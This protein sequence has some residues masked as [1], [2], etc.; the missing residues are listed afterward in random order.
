MRLIF[1]LVSVVVLLTAGLL[2]G[3]SFMDWNKYKPQIIEQVKTLTGYDIA[4]GGDIGLSL[5]PS[6][7]VHL[8][9]VT[10]SAPRKVKA[11]NVISVKQA[12]VSLALL[13]LL[14]K[15]I[16]VSTVSLVDPDIRFEI[17]PGGEQGWMSDT[18]KSVQAAS[19]SGVATEGQ[20]TPSNSTDN[21]ALNRIEIKNGRVEFTDH[22]KGVSYLAEKIDV[23]VSADTLKGPFKA[24]GNLVYNNQ[25]LALN[26]KTGRMVSDSKDLELQVK[27]SAPDAGA[28]ISFSGVVGTGG[29]VE[30]QGETS[31]SVQNMARAVAALSG[32]A[33]SGVPAQKLSF[34]GLVTVGP[35]EAKMAN[36]DFTVGDASGTGTVTVQNVLAKNPVKVDADLTLKGVLDLDALAPASGGQGKAADGKA[37][38]AAPKKA[39]MLPASITLPMA[40]DGSVKLNA[41]GIKTGGQTLKGVVLDI[42]KTGPRIAAA[43]KLLNVPGGGNLDGKAAINFASSSVSEK[44]GAVTYADPSLVFN[45]TGAVDQWP[46]LMAALGQKGPAANLTDTAQ[47]VLSGDVTGGTVNVK[48][49]NLKL[50]D[51]AATL[52]AAYRPD[53]AGGKPDVMVDLTTDRIDVDAIQARMNGGKAKPAPA[54]D[55]PAA[56]PDMKAALKPV[57]EFSLPVNLTFDISAGSARV[58]GMDIK[59]VRLKGVSQGSSLK[60]DAASAENIMGASAS[61]KGQVAS[62]SDLSGIDMDFYGRTDDAEGLM[63][64][65]KVDASKLPTKIGPAE[66]K[67]S[68]KGKLESLGFVANIDALSGQLNAAGTVVDALGSPAFDNLTFGVKHPNFVQAMKIVSPAF[69]GGAGLARPFDFYAKTTRSGNAYDLTDIKGNFGSTSMTGTLNVNTGGARPDVSGRVQ[70]G[71]LPLDSYLGA[72]AGAS[73]GSDSGGGGSAAPKADS[74]WSTAPLDFGWMKSADMDLDLS[75]SSI[76]YGGWNFQQPKTKFKIKDGVLDVDNLNAGLFGGQ[77]TLTANVKSGAKVGDPVSLSVKSSMTDVAVEPLVFALSGSKRLQGSGTVSLNMDVA[78]NGGSASALVGSLDGKSTL[79]GTDVVLK[80][81]D[82]AALSQAIMDSAKPLDR[83]SQIVSSS[84]T[85][86]QTQFDTVTG[87]YNIDNGIVAIQSMKMEGAS[88]LIVSQGTVSLPQKYIDTTHTIT[89]PQAKKMNPFKVVIKGP[90]SNPTNTFGRGI[91]DTILREKVQDKVMEKLPDLLGD[92]T[93]D[94]L[95]GLGILPGQKAPAAAPVPAPAPVA[96]AAPA[97]AGTWADPAQSAPVAPAAPEPAPVTEE[98]KDPLQQILENP[99]KPEEALKGVLDGLLQ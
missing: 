69:S 96:P 80:G 51:M 88:A 57:Q 90:L 45:A 35:D 73:G 34:K 59:G 52:S 77:V 4:I 19:K 99:D 94:K 5:L 84:T 27:I 30:A 46:V 9:Q 11:E 10:V 87:D 23:Q 63:K 74:G 65:L 72:K 83:L 62:L 78:G 92:K 12:D 7:S 38:E 1:W 50:G 76:T 81:F 56:K 41:E 16:E 97:D 95:R 6:P 58:N 37:G 22:Q 75:A 36:A 82:F 2:I 29:A 21:I 91:F 32:S 54:A 42:I 18:L 44:T 13:P 48:N 53:G 17:L 64:T 40:I 79:R 25:N 89:L 15:K 3:P 67:V 70:V 33:A 85:G 24:D 71:N 43:V 39:G 49:S 68:L 14:S 47:F 8:E 20:S 55:A 31:L 60:L 26:I 86:G 98:P 93:T 61:L 66:A 28:D